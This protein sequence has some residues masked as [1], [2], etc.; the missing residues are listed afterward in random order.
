MTTKWMAVGLLMTALGVAAPATAQAGIRIVIGGD[1]HRE[2]EAFRVGMHRGYDDGMQRGVKDAHR[3]RDMRYWNH[4]AYR[5]GDAGY[6]HGC[7][8]RHQYAAGYRQGFERGYRE[9]FTAER[10]RLCARARFDRRR[11][12]F[13]RRGYGRGDDE[14]YDHGDQS[15]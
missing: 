15:W 1:Q 4:S 13:R 7:G 5:N 11:D 9:G 6:H 14:R 10:R 12:D 8:P 3:H 2:R